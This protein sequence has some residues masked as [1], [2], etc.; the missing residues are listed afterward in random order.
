MTRNYE[1][2]LRRLE[3]KNGRLHIVTMNLGESNADALSRY[4]HDIDDRDLVVFV[5]RFFRNTNNDKL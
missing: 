1:R 3:G 4:P 2:R 5:V